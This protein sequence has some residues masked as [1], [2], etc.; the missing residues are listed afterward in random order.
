MLPC[1]LTSLKGYLVNE[2]VFRYSPLVFPL[3]GSRV[4]FNSCL[5]LFTW[6]GCKITREMIV[7]FA[8][9]RL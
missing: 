7:C 3:G 6:A 1:L 9:Q 2:E 8:D 4:S 5:M